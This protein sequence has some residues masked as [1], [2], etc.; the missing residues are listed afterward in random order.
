MMLVADSGSSKT[1]WVFDGRDGILNIHTA[2][3]NPVRDSED[4]I[5]S[6]LA[7]VREKTGEVDAIYFYGAGCVEPFADTM[8]KCLSKV[9]GAEKVE[10]HSDLLGAARALCGKEEGIACI[11]G[12]GS[13]SC[14]CM[15]GEIMSNVPPLG[16]ILGDEGSGASLGK[17]LLGD[18]LKGQMEPALLDQLLDGY[19]LTY[20]DIIQK[21]Y[22]EPQANKFLASLTY[23]IAEHRE[24]PEIHELLVNEFRSFLKRN[25]L[26]YNK[27]GV[28]VH[29]IGSISVHFEKELSEALELEGLEKG[30]I[31][32][33]PINKMLEYH[34]NM[35]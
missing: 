3:L 14:H 16:Y 29:F 8:R 20:S 2:G 34:K 9:F 18:L 7:E 13:N 31:I 28:Q 30:N 32:A 33:S 12:T 26:M 27:K 11:L 22:R 35:L 5:L 23:F 15:D 25:V 21:V 10:V 17:H 19:E 6:V 4:V 24:H 1:D